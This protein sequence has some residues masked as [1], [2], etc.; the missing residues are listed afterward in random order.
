MTWKTVTFVGVACEKSVADLWNYQEIIAE[1][2]PGVIAEFGTLMGGSAFY[3]AHVLRAARLDSRVLT[4]D[5]EPTRIHPRALE[6]PHIEFLHA[7]STAPVVR[8]ALFR[9]RATN[10][11]R[12]SPFSTAFAGGLMCSQSCCP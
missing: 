10:L 9:M 12:C 1:L 11:G 8:D 2:R 6:C 4:V 7:D 5:V 3:F